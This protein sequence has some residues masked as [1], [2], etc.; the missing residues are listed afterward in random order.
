[1]PQKNLN[2]KSTGET[3]KVNR[4]PTAPLIKLSE[5]SF[6]DSGSNLGQASEESPKEKASDE[7]PITSTKHMDVLPL[8]VKHERVIQPTASII[9]TATTETT[10]TEAPK[11]SEP[12]RPAKESDANSTDTE[13]SK[14]EVEPEK[15]EPQKEAPE[16]PVATSANEPADIDSSKPE[17]PS[18]QDLKT[19]ADAEE[20][21]KKLKEYTENRQY[22]LPINAVAQK[23]SI[24]VSAGLTVVVFLLAIVLIDLMLDSGTIL[25]IQKIPHTHFF[26]LSHN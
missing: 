22:Y 6:M 26:S 12:L 7:K 1:M 3:I 14:A 23:R 21:D 2:S 15:P 18:Q 24:K 19:K 17:K 13:V 11:E 5:R 8:N 25:L 20:R 9:P 10:P 4:K 16:A